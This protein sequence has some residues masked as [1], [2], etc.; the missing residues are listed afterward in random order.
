MQTICCNQDIK[1][2]SNG[3]E[4]KDVTWYFSGYVAK[5]QRE[6]SNSSALLAKHLAFYKK[7]E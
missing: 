6:I 5:N 3:M 4:M 2:I 1:L 7:Q